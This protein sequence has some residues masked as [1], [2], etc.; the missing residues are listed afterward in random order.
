MYAIALAIVLCLGSFSFA[1]RPQAPC[2]PV[3]HL[4]HAHPYADCLACK[5]PDEQF[6]NYCRQVSVGER[7]PVRDVAFAPVRLFLAIRRR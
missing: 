6:R 2:S 7:T 5:H 4:E 3:A 1:Q